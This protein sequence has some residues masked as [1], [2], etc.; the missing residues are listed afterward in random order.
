MSNFIKICS[1]VTK[2]DVYESDKIS[3]WN[4]FA[5]YIDCKEYIPI[6]I[7]KKHWIYR[8]LTL[9]LMYRTSIHS[10]SDLRKRPVLKPLSDDVT[11]NQNSHKWSTY[12]S[13][14]WALT[15]FKINQSFNSENKCEIIL[16][17]YGENRTKIP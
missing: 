9:K 4:I 8:F 15:S 7:F 17:K 14:Y 10:T 3:K 6:I 2:W 16:Y 12:L 11:Q 5:L 1:V 13:F